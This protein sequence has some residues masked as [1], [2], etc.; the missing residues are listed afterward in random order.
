M[1]LYILRHGQTEFNRL[2]IVQGSG[3]DSELNETGY[4]QAR[5]FYE[6]YQNIDFQLVVTS[7]LLRTRQTVQGFLDKNIPWQQ[8]P[9][10]NEI[11]WG[12]HEGKFQNAVQKER[13]HAMVA[14]WQMGNL[15][16]AL[17]GGESARQLAERIGSFVEWVKKRSEKRILIATH[18]RALRCLIAQLKGW[19][20]TQMEEIAHTNTGLYIAKRYGNNWLFERENDT[21]HLDKLKEE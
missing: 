13:Y 9:L 1:T 10:I 18:G 15:D 7:T 14:Q 21:S 5:A 20:L 6:T 19:P 12:T 2:N 11:S 17:P 3:T 16:A 8:T 4:T